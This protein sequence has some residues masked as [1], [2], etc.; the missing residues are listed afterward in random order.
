MQNI[1]GG[2]DKEI[3]LNDI[4]KIIGCWNGLSKKIISEQT[5]ADDP[6]PMK[7]AVAF[8][9]TIKDSK[10][11]AE[12]FQGVISTYIM[13]H[14]R[15]E[16]SLRCEVEHVDGSYN[17][18]LR[19][20]K[21]DWLK[22]DTEA[23]MCRILTNARCL[24]EGVDV[25]ALD[26]VLF[27][28]PRNSIVDVVQSVGR[29]MRV[30]EGKKYGYVILPIGVPAGVPPEEALK[31]NEKYKVV[32][33]VLQSL[34]AHDDRF[35]AMINQIELNKA[36]PDQ[37]Q[38]I[39]VG[40]SG[41]GEGDGSDKNRKPTQLEMPMNQLEEWKDAIYAK[42][43]AKCG[44]RRYWEQW[45][46]DV[47]KIAQQHT[48]RIEGVLSSKDSSARK[49]FDK[50]LK[51]IQKNINPSILEP[52][53]IEM[54]SQHL[55]TR[56]V[57]D[58]LFENYSFT[59]KNPVSK[60]M[61]TV[62]DKLEKHALESEV[63]K[64][65]GFYESVKL[66][67]KGISNA[68]GRQKVIVELYDKFFKLAFPKMT[69]RLGIV[70]TP[71]EVV[72]FIIHSAEFALKKHFG[73]SLTNEGVHIL[74]PFTGTGTFIVR[75][76]QSGLIKPN[77]LER[78][79]KNE[80]H[81]NEIVLLAYYIAAINIEETFHGKSETDY[82]PFNGIV[83]TDTFQ[84]AESAQTDLGENEL[85]EN[86]ERVKKQKSQKIQVVIS[87]PPY[88]VGQTDANDNN[89]N[90]KY[91]S[92]DE[93]IRSTYAALSTAT[94]KNSLY[95]SYIRAIRWASD[96]IDNGVVGFVTN[97]S[98]IDGNA[99]DGLRKSL[100]K[101]FDAIYCFNL[102]GNQ[103][104]S[105]ELSRQEGGKIFGSGSRT[106]VAIT[107]LIKNIQKSNH[108]ALYY[109]DIGDYLSREEKLKIISEYK[110]I[111]NVKWSVLMPND[112]GDW[113]N[114]RN[115][116]FD[117]FLPLAD[118]ILNTNPSFE[119]YSSGVKT[120]RDVWV[121]NF[122]LKNGA[123]SVKKTIAHYMKEL[124]RYQSSK[125]KITNLEKFV[126]TD[127][128]LISWSSSLLPNIGRGR[129][130][131]FNDK[132][133]VHCLYRPFVKQHLYFESMLNDR[134]GKM[135]TL[136]PNGQSDNIVISVTGSGSS[137]PFSALATNTIPDYE[138]ISKGQCFPL[139]YYL[140]NNEAELGLLNYAKSK[141][142]Q[143][144]KKLAIS[145][146]TLKL[147]QQK[148]KDTSLKKEEI[149][150]YIY[151][152]LHSLD[153][154]NRYQNDLKKMLPRIPVVKE[155]KTFSKL[156]KKL[157]DLHINYE[158]AV[159]YNLREAYSTDFKSLKNDYRVVEMKYLKNGKET[160]RTS[161]IYNSKIKLTGIPLEAYEYQV[162]GKS[163]IDWIIERYAISSDKDNGIQNDPNEWSDDPKYII[164]LVKR[165]VTVSVET[166]NIVKALPPL[167][168][169]K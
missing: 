146:F 142:H 61:Q 17:V 135:K 120:N 164:E 31:D 143:P 38:I 53:A 113:I 80:L 57:F 81:A 29:I 15:D 140:E 11:V 12:L 104:T 116:D 76:L 151:G 163:A 141:K 60:A 159:P 139:Y 10:K 103:R 19:N 73:K 24:A 121:Y 131:T 43:V 88:S 62:L 5:Q 20:Q 138:L 9:S 51:S 44:D 68:E 14:N 118:N 70:Y 40:G 27:L 158:A 42:M 47:A 127:K 87:N 114:Q 122:S 37:I 162:N 132:N 136:F 26:A 102:R 1:F 95:D 41:E 152:I 72:D 119:I 109:N 46:S 84:L 100:T 28:N 92:L 86:N 156:G 154:K 128:T 59:Q 16:N 45:A 155:F 89:Q 69:E 79:Y 7:R 106:P 99:A 126:N 58:A 115:P 129:A 74:D 21:L 13:T 34:R 3:K 108:C 71:V 124:E 55:I 85:L 48:T 101:E 117:N 111:E 167:D 23:D 133:F 52:E 77:D 110:S 22:A 78:K 153:Y 130:L 82:I 32:W 49:S 35:N 25:P 160:D 125:T 39:G 137:K 165:I 66:R 134:Q 91:P 94:L 8:A 50:F 63:E 148:L 64:L 97:G 147:F 75:L 65:K 54:L 145:D 157:V 161:I 2:A 96:R 112:E 33:Q 105:G 4:V 166:M 107:L 169:I 150:Y 93:K 36:R 168:I 56:P 123:N 30:S 144:Q 18:L 83:L 98:F 67:V 6:N 149:F 90:L